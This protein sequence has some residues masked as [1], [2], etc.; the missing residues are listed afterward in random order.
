MNQ[1]T[2][3]EAGKQRR[4][5]ILL[6]AK[7]AARNR[8]QKRFA[9]CGVITIAIGALVIPLMLRSQHSKVMPVEKPEIAR[10]SPPPV[11]PPPSIAIEYVQTD[12]TITDRL[13]IKP[14]PPRWTSIGDDEFL[15]ALADAGQPAGLVYINGKAILLSRW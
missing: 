6:L 11:G 9:L 5:Q 4:Q 2:L 13:T 3:S 12:P 14:Q 10:V 7:A 1:E 8:R 15:K